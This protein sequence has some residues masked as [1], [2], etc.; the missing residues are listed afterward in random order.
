M[1]YSERRKISLD[2]KKKKII[3][4]TRGNIFQPE[5]SSKRV[6]K[7]T[8]KS[9]KG[10]RYQKEERKSFFPENKFSYIPNEKSL[11]KSVIGLKFWA[12]PTPT[13]KYEYIR[14]SPSRTSFDLHTFKRCVNCKHKKCSEPLHKA[15]TIPDFQMEW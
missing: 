7:N 13:N 6:L 2:K 5:K 4:N 8:Q 1:Q 10:W 3:N 9:H 14:K 15:T 11:V 12:N